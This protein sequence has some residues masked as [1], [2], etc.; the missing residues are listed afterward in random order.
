MNSDGSSNCYV[1]LSYGR[2]EIVSKIV[3]D[4]SAPVFEEVFVF[5]RQ[6]K[7]YKLQ[8]EVWHASHASHLSDSFLG[9]TSV[10]PIAKPEMTHF[11]LELV[12]RVT[13][14]TVKEEVPGFVEISTR[15]ELGKA[16]HNLV[17]EITVHRARGLAVMDWFCLGCAG[18]GMSDPYIVA[19]YGNQE[20]VTHVVE[21]DLNPT[22]ESEHVFDF[23]PLH[24]L[25][26]T[27]MD[28]DFGSVF[29]DDFMGVLKVSRMTL[30]EA[31]GKPMNR[32]W[33]ELQSR[34]QVRFDGSPGPDLGE[35]EL[36]FRIS[37]RADKCKM[38]TWRERRTG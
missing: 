12:D 5:P 18:H 6:L 19:K 25:V 15:R 20:H 3:C 2:E 17:L 10:Q 32:E 22:F 16:Y 1:K 26:L 29:G 23:H 4:T 13:S 36:S 28:H 24:P 27:V 30:T 34:N 11:C 14:A 33:Y 37:E 7:I 38:G 9:Q 35:L 31:V 8:I 21:K